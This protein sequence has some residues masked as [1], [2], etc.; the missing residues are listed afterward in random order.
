MTPTK[1]IEAWAP[2]CWGREYE[3]VPSSLRG[4]REDP[5]GACRLAGSCEEAT[6]DRRHRHDGERWCE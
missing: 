4:Y 1:S 2:R 3:R 6:L 5:C